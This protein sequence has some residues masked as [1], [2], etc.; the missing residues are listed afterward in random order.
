MAQQQALGGG[1]QRFLGNIAA[2]LDRLP[3]TWRH[4][5]LALLVQL[6]WAGALATDGIAARLY[7]FI[8]EPANA[9]TK[10][11]YSTLYAFQVGISIL[12]GDY[13]IGL[14]ADKYGRRPAIMLATFLAG[15]FI[16]TFVLT[17]N[18]WWLLL[19]S[20]LGTLGAGGMLAT[21]VVYIAEIVAPEQRG[22]LTM[23]AQTFAFILLAI[24]A[25]LL[26]FYWVPSH[27][28]AYLFVLAG[29]QL[30]FVL[31]LVF[32]RLPES[33]RWLE[34]HNRAA[35]ANEQV[36][37]LE[38]AVQGPGTEMEPL[39]LEEHPVVAGSDDPVPFFELFR[40][41]YA[42][43]TILLLIAWTLG[44]GGIIYGVGAYALV[45]VA[46]RGFG[47]HF[48]FGLYFVGVLIGGLLTF[49]N[50][51]V[52]EVVERRVM[53]LV[54]A[55]TFS[56]AWALIYFTDS[57]PALVVFYL[58]S[59]SGAVIWIV[60][61][62]GYTANAFPTRLRATGTGWTDGIGHIGAWLG[63]V[64]AGELFVVGPDHLGWILMII[65]P[66]ALLPALLIFFFGLNQRGAVL[67][68]LST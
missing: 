29:F 27:W 41:Q 26:P 39:D 32:L 54:G 42:K 60:N 16:W 30:L 35:E 64:L 58:I 22:R 33:P 8:W 1:V 24:L 31:P 34:T 46:D 65:I 21:N 50:S 57:R 28:H 25:A 15:A 52:G 45:Y 3:L 47:S 23:A 10:F 62:Y 17:T 49:L 67:E 5:E 4:W 56:A 61:M 55:V 9:I 40:G 19:F 37:R 14:F 11:E 38:H 68:Q 48:T 59:A 53:A 6:A 51:F 43:R 36:V 18:F 20:I 12:L 66:G 2:R 7:P 44:Y 63:A 13:L